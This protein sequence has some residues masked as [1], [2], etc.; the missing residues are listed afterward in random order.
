MLKRWW[1]AWKAHQVS[2]RTFTA[3]ISV[4]GS[5][6][7]VWLMGDKS[8]MS[9]V[10]GEVLRRLD[11]T[12]GRG[13]LLISDPSGWELLD[14]WYGEKVIHRLESANDMRHGPRRVI[15]ERG[16]YVAEMSPDDELCEEAVDMCQE[17]TRVVENMP[18]AYR[19][20]LPYIVLYGLPPAGIASL[21]KVCA[22]LKIPMV[23]LTEQHYFWRQHEG[24][25][26]RAMGSHFTCHLRAEKVEKVVSLAES[27]I[28]FQI[29]LDE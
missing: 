3:T 26:H 4:A 21:G 13:L 7:L 20:P 9:G 14:D 5:S 18:A 17:L 11:D 1:N 23:C 29:T 6:P 27:G 8:D 19:H 25:A 28:G 10:T 15:E 24:E 12:H 22:Q 16:V 2:L